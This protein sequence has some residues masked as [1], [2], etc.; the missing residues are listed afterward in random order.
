MTRAGRRWRAAAAAL[1]LAG[2]APL[3]AQTGAVPLGQTRT[4]DGH[5][6]RP[7]PHDA[8]V[9][10]AGVYVVLHRVGQDH[11]GPLD[12]AR[13]GPGGQ[14][15]FTYKTSGAPDAVYF[16]STRYA[17][18]AYFTAPLEAQNVSGP[19]ADIMVYDTASAGI[20]LHLAGR[21]LVIGAPGADGLRDVAE[22]WDLSNDSTKTLV[23]R[24]SL[25]PLWTA[26]LP[27]GAVSPQVQ[28]GDIAA[29]AVTFANGQVRLYAPVSPGV[30][31]LAIA[32]QL[33]PGAFP[34]AVP[35]TGGTGMLEVLLEE[36]S[37]RPDLAGLKQTS[38]VTSQ[39]RTFT[40]YLAQEVP[41][42]AV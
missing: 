18:I 24:D 34:L 5:V 10:V 37:A 33:P 14:L 1:L 16:A 2:A 4:V 20:P 8:P 32:F 26:S 7:G 11:A 28:G 13:T 3:A 27:A 17:G 9:A 36:A 29:G 6:R 41:P 42:G 35:M 19:D 22:V 15:H 38:S 25:T 23:A 12:S 31:Q 39:G 40:R 21:H 30:R